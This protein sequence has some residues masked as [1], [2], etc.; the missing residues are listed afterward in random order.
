ML[1]V[2]A[3]IVR[4]QQIIS[5]MEM[6]LVHYNSIPPG[7]IV[8]IWHLCQGLEGMFSVI[9]EV[10]KPKHKLIGSESR[11]AYQRSMDGLLWKTAH[12]ILQ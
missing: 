5:V 1:T 10:G 7:H 2:D 6:F 4:T 12:P 8:H 11:A 9:L 3:V